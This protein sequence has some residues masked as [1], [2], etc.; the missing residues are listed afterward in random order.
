MTLSRKDFFRQ[1]FFSLGETLLK[2]GETVRDV[3]GSLYSTPVDTGQDIEQ[4]I[5]QEQ[6]PAPDCNKVAKADNQLCMAKYCGCFSC[7]ERCEAQ[8]VIVVMGEGI[9]IDENLCTGCG[10][11]QY[12]CPMTPKAVSMQPRT[13]ILTPSAEQAELPPQKGESPC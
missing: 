1:S 6:E 4:D 10:T 9:R 8:A 5:E 2:V 11:C 3:Q 12:V 13:T 7:V